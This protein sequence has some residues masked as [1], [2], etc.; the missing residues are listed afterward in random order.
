MCVFPPPPTST[1]SDVQKLS[2]TFTRSRLN[3][4]SPHH[5][6]HAFCIPHS[7]IPQPHIAV[8]PAPLTSSAACSP[9]RPHSSPT[10]LLPHP[11][12]CARAPD[13]TPHPLP[14]PCLRPSRRVSS[15]SLAYPSP[16]LSAHCSPLLL[17]VLL[18]LTRLF[19]SAATSAHISLSCSARP[20]LSLLSLAPSLPPL[21]PLH[22]FRKT[23]R[24]N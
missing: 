3:T 20:S 18:L 21:N 10:F 5:L 14:T 12:V 16:L 1:P 15:P 11:A 19:A 7:A 23:H 2:F 6:P 4:F 13:T 9:D 22:L 24:P 8:P 17:R